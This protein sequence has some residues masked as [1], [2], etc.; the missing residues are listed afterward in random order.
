MTSWPGPSGCAAASATGSVPGDARPAI[1]RGRS[2][3]SMRPVSARDSRPGPSSTNSV[4][5]I[6]TGRWRTPTSARRR[7]NSPPGVGADIADCL[8]FDTASASAQALDALDPSLLVFAKLD[9]WPELA[10]QAARI[11]IPVALVAATVRPGSGRLGPVARALLKPGYEALRIAGAISNDD[12]ERLA[13]LGVA[14][15]RIRVTGDPRSDSVLSRRRSRARQRPA[16]RA[17]QRLHSW[18]GL[19]GRSMKRS[20]SRPS[21]RCALAGPMRASSWRR[22]SQRRTRSS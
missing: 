15:E 8:P 11:G 16:A 22:T 21:C 2:P 5:G 1:R 9:V 12:A 14:R 13:R 20:S 18:Q 19:P 6:R 10:T 7:R 4:D 3:G 17:R